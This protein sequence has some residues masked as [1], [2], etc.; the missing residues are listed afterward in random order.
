MGLGLIQIPRYRAAAELES[1]K[2]V[3]VLPQFPP[4]ALPVHVLYSHTRQL[5]PRLR[6]VIDWM[7]EQF[8]S[9]VAP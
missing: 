8:R 2:L 7:A 3:E 1:G 6:V 4:S 9:M 5:S